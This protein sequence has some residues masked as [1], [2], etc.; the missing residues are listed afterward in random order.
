MELSL[1]EIVSAEKAFPGAPQ[2]IPREDKWIEIVSP[3]DIAGVTIEGLRFRGAALQNRPDEAVTFQLEYIPP[4]ANVRGGP[5]WRLEWRP[6]SPHD[7]K[8]VGPPEWRFRKQAGSHHHPFTLNW[9]AQ[10]RLVRRGNLPIAVPNP[11]MADASYDGF[12]A[13]AAEQLKI[14]GLHASAVPPPWQEF[15]DL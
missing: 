11:D 12:V 15:L 14:P 7:N 10:A 9:D 3:L 1:T 2:W 5:L 6:V 8:G 4:R 13:F